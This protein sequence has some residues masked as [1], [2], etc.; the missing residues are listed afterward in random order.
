MDAIEE[1][2]ALREK[3]MKLVEIQDA[4]LERHSR[5]YVPAFVRDR[6]RTLDS[7]RYECSV[8][9]LVFCWLLGY[10]P[11]TLEFMIGGQYKI[12]NEVGEHPD[13]TLSPF[14][15]YWVLEM[16]YRQEP[17]VPETE[18][19][20]ENARTMLAHMLWGPGNIP[21]HSSANQCPSLRN[22]AH[23]E[24]MVPLSS[25]HEGQPVQHDREQS[26]AH[27]RLLDVLDLPST[28]HELHQTVPHEMPSS[29][30]LSP[31]GILHRSSTP[32]N[33][34]SVGGRDS[35]TG[36]GFLKAPNGGS[37]IHEE[38][39]P[40]HSD[41][42][43]H[44]SLP[45]QREP[46]HAGDV[47]FDFGQSFFRTPPPFAVPPDILV[48]VHR[49]L[50]ST[51]HQ[52]DGC[53]LSDDFL[54]NLKVTPIQH[55][56]PADLSDGQPGSSV[57]DAPCTVDAAATFDG[58][59]AWDPAAIAKRGETCGASDCDTETQ[60]SIDAST[61]TFDVDYPSFYLRANSES[62]AP[63]R[64]PSPLRGAE[65]SRVS[66]AQVSPYGP[67]ISWDSILA[68]YVPSKPT[69]PGC[70]MIPDLIVVKAGVDG[71]PHRV[72]VIV[73]NKVQDNPIGQLIQ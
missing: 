62:D 18:T 3:Y 55:V 27:K 25:Q 49:P 59:S 69:G 64:T 48:P 57:D 35:P 28:S 32:H 21:R 29:H 72:L 33:S 63:Q 68:R 9:M 31:P 4:T 44:H 73:E 61:S 37:A 1:L 56:D 15:I 19:R 65:D 14:F 2:A 70:Y 60:R 8:D 38:P 36:N 46:D 45:L 54:L 52:N 11:T 23:N 50:H 51:P 20:F 24:T 30:K 53:T 42:V 13:P 34:L 66:N 5:D 7:P 26:V 10:F 41:T 39:Q 43:G 67:D 71:M 17:D 40:I 47:S 12:R 16:E 58:E 6:L 22:F